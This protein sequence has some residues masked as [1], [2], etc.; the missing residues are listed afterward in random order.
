M[1]YQ[2]DWIM[3]QIENIIQLIARFFFKKYT[4]HYEIID[5]TNHTQTDL[6]YKELLELLNS[7]EINEAE[8]LLYERI[9][10]NDRNYLMV[11]VD[12]YK[13]LNELSDEQL[14]SADFSREEIRSGLE[15]IS[16]MFGLIL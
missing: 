6:L 7:L 15:E 12:F 3:R 11:A 9:K 8:N 1:F 5:E 2:K 14:E 13:R 16:R 4:V 10:A